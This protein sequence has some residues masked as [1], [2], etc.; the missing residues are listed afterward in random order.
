MPK[1]T[2]AL[3]Q[4]DPFPLTAADL[5]YFSHS[6]LF[7]PDLIRQGESL[8]ALE[9]LGGPTGLS[10]KLDSSLKFGISAE[11]EVERREKA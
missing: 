7:N 6:A 10:E 1:D 2:D 4:L 5:R 3:F 9:K 8:L 11:S